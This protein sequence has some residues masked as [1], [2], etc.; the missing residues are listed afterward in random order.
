MRKVEMS[1]T[2]KLESLKYFE[3]VSRLQNGLVYVALFFVFWLI[4]Q[5]IF[6]L[7]FTWIEQLLILIVFPIAI[8]GTFFLG[9]KKSFQINRGDNFINI[10]CDLSELI[11][12][13]NRC[14]FDL[15]EQA[16]DYYLLKN[17][18]RVGCHKKLTVTGVSGKCIVFGSSFIENAEC[19][20]GYIKNN[21][22]HQSNINRKTNNNGND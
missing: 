5:M 16:G 7:K 1:K 22:Y 6:S 3:S 15:Q 14:G 12:S 8:L 9:Y 21:L 4:N 18:F 20:F 10:Q 2:E 11:I 13:L 17:R 19:R